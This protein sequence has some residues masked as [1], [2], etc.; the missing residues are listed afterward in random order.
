MKYHIVISLIIWKSYHIIDLVLLL[1]N[2]IIDL[3]W[4]AL[5]HLSMIFNYLENHC[6]H[7]LPSLWFSLHQLSYILFNQQ[8]SS[9][10]SST[11]LDCNHDNQIWFDLWLYQHQLSNTI[12]T[13]DF[14]HSS[15]LTI[16][17]NMYWIH[18]HTTL[19]DQI[20]IHYHSSSKWNY[21]MSI[22]K[23]IIFTS[24]LLEWFKISPWTSNTCLMIVNHLIDSTIHHMNIHIVSTLWIFHYSSK[25]LILSQIQCV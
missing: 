3:L 24:S 5:S 9:C 18:F 10:Y 16:H 22:F 13:S 25:S 7:S 15:S 19:S 8:I 20:D 6:D 14:H 12:S 21:C 11:Y 4:E 23:L 17:H 1:S 2:D